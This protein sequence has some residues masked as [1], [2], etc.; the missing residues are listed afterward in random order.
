MD[1]SHILPE[2]ELFID[3]D[4]KFTIRVFGWI[5]PDTHQIY[6]D[7]GWSVYFITVYKLLCKLN[8]YKICK[9]IEY[10]EG[11]PLS[12]LEKH[13]ISKRFHLPSLLQT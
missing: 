2:L 12:H 5:L 4:L 13:I 1:E 8:S 9:G 11:K 6:K 10:P 3:K 7:H